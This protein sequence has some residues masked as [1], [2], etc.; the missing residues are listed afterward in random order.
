MAEAVQRLRGTFF[1]LNVNSLLNLVGLLAIAI[2]LFA[3]VQRVFE[4]GGTYFFQTLGF[5]LAEGA[6]YALVALGYTMVYGII[7]L[8]NFAHGD[9]FTLGAFVSLP[10]IGAFG[11]TEGQKAS[12]GLYAALLA[13]AIIVMLI[14]GGVNVLIERI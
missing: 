4:G 13:I 10:L 1:A 2:A 7:E 6:I 9:V 11:L 8:I 3:T 5:G 14:L 12:V